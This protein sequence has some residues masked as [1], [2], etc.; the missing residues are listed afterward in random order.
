MKLN[1]LNP[2]VPLTEDDD[3]VYAWL[4]PATGPERIRGVRLAYVQDI[5]KHHDQLE[6]QAA[7]KGDERWLGNIDRMRRSV[8]DRPA[9]QRF[10]TPDLGWWQSKK[11]FEEG[12]TGFGGATK[13]AVL[14][15][16]PELVIVNSRKE[17][18]DAAGFGQE[19]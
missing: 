8:A 13:D 3:K 5:D 2:D 15:K 18:L 19:N 12:K 6:R 16:H 11:D 10:Y 4:E 17:A 14:A 9:H 1:E 7:N